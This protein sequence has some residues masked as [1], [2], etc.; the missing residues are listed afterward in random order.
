MRD[1]FRRF[2]AA[3]LAVFMIFQF[4]AGDGSGIGNE[5]TQAFAAT[6]AYN[7]NLGTGVLQTGDDLH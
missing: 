1:R 3:L 6:S 5:I 7:I 4:P 2:V